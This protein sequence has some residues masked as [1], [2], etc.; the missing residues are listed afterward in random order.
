MKHHSPSK[1]IYNLGAKWDTLDIAFGF[2]DGAGNTAHFIIKGDGKELFKSGEIKPKQISKASVSVKGVK[3][4]SL[5]ISN[6]QD[7]RGSWTVWL[8]PIIKR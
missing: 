4:L 1:I 8:N 5:E 3:N 2:R 6:P 7:N